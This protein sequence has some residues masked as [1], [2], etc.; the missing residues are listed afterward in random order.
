MDAHDLAQYYHTSALR[1]DGFP[2]PE[3]YGP[4]GSL[5]GGRT[6]SITRFV[7]STMAENMTKPQIEEL[8]GYIGK[9]HRDYQDNA[10]Q[11]DNLETSWGISHL[12]KSV[13][14]RGM[15]LGVVVT[16]DKP[17]TNLSRVPGSIRAEKRISA[18]RS[19]D[20]LPTGLTHGD[21]NKRNVLLKPDGHIALIDWD[22]MGHT[23]FLKEITLG[24]LCCGIRSEPE[25]HFSEEDAMAFL[26]AYHNVRP[27][28]PAEI[29]PLQEMIDLQ[30][31]RDRIA[32]NKWFKEPVT[33]D[34]AETLSGQA[35]DWIK[36][37]DLAA[38]LGIETAD[39]SRGY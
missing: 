38:E 25:P 14:T 3:Q 39:R 22:N 7:E 2:V 33:T 18:L 6:F 37:L 31:F 19:L 28:T 4:F 9:L 36:K 16:S 1:E 5:S 20:Y 29:H 17:F 21:L 12:L 8:A 15:Q 26:K 35:R 24:T 13:R 10:R 32:L 34:V 11:F 23:N 30:M 27:I